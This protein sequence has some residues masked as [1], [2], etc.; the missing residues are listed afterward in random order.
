MKDFAAIDFETANRNS[1]SVCS[2]GIVIVRDGKITEEIYRLI[3]PAPNYYS[4]ANVRVHSLTRADTDPAPHFDEVWTEIAPRIEGLPLVAHFS[5]FDEGCLRAA[6]ERY[7]MTWPGYRFYCTCTASRKVL[8]RMLPN[9]KLDTVASFLGFER[10]RH[11]YAM[12]DARA[13]AFIACNL[14]DKAYP[15]MR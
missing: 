5:R 8:G 13:C 15:D 3:R 2:V 14:L 10:F 7:G 11:H 9:H 12:D 1:C 6:M 4:P